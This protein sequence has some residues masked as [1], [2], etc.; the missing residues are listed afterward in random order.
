MD[1]SY[2]RAIS[3]GKFKRKNYYLTEKADKSFKNQKNQSL[4]L[5]IKNNES[6]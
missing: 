2:S 6:T 4:D 1:K 5:P 3:Y